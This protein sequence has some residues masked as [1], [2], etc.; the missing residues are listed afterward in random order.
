M[1][2]IALFDPASSGLPLK[3]AARDLG[4]KVICIFTHSMKSYKR[5][6]RVTSEALFSDC[7]EVI[8]SDDKEEIVRKLKASKYTIKASIAA[9]EGGVELAEQVADAL[10]LVT[11]PI[12]LSEAR[13]DKGEMRRFFKKSG[14]SCPDFALCSSEDEVRQFA[15]THSF[16]LVIKTPKGASTCQVFV[17]EDLDELL[18]GY[19]DILGQEDLFGHFAKRAV[20]EDYI[21]GKEYIVDTFSDGEK[22]HVT[23]VW[24]YDKI[25]SA[26]FKNI[27]Y[28]I[29]SLPLTD[30]HLKNLMEYA[31]KAAKYFRVQFG[32]AH[33]E[34]KD[35]PKRG[36]TLIEIGARLPGVR[37]PMYIQKFSNFDPYRATI[38]VFTKGKTSVP[39]P[40]V[41][42]KHIAVVFCP[43]L[44]GGKIQKILGLDHIRKL[45]SY[46]DHLVN[47]QEGDTVSPSTYIGTTLCFVFLAHESREQLFQDMEK[48]HE[49]FTVEFF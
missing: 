3:K 37:L 33:I 19:R 46:Q 48:A 13:R 35:D 32:T 28:N 43:S 12:E 40:I 31:V 4:Y 11:N 24:Y 23:D 17:C 8:E 47:V 6:Y 9:T 5:I 30:P 45:S 27:Y 49:L 29:I 15:S 1:D 2:A 39:E 44:L 20:V 16:P 42:S 26:N 14:L 41:Y 22:I 10:G 34:I 25:E 7:D 21:S 36:P 38:E 18:K